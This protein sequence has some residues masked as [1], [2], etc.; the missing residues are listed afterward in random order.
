[1][2]AHSSP[3]QSRQQQS[4]LPP[5]L[6]TFKEVTTHHP[7]TCKKVFM[8][9]VFLDPQRCGFCGS[10]TVPP[11]NRCY[12]RSGLQSGALPSEL[13]PQIGIFYIS[14]ARFFIYIPTHWLALSLDSWGRNEQEQT[15]LSVFI[16]GHIRTPLL[17]SF[18]QRE[19]TMQTWNCKRI[20]MSESIY[21]GKSA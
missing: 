6:L 9:K 8:I 19:S 11:D 7:K 17:L 10:N 20:L 13:K 14:A 5:H 15:V 21:W 3:G 16:N 12:D 2:P 4:R 1:M 18:L